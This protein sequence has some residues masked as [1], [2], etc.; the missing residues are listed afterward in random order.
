M[1]AASSL[2]VWGFLHRLI[3]AAGPRISISPLPDALFLIEI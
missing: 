3:L 2:G 1:K